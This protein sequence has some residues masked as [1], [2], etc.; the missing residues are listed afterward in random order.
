AART[1]Y[2]GGCDY[3]AA[4]EALNKLARK[5]DRAWP[6]RVVAIGWGPW[7][8]V[9]IAARYPDQLLSDRGLAYFS[10]RTGCERF[11]EELVWGPKGDAEVVIYAAKQ[12]AKQISGGAL[13][14]AKAAAGTA[15]Y[16]G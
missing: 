8:E 2:A 6:G 7:A 3:A 11:F 15:R 12:D 16:S 1:G 5:L 13:G 10:T 9:G 4:N 14:L